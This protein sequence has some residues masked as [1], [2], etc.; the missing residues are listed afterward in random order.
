[1]KYSQ[2]IKDLEKVK[3][4]IGGD[5]EVTITDGFNAIFFEGDF[6]IEVF[7]EDDGTKIIDIGVGGT[8]VYHD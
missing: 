7:E 5:P 6:V 2:F 8:Q 4:Q 3:K 1:M